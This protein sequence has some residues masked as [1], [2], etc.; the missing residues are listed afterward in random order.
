MGSLRT[1]I[2][3]DIPPAIQKSIQ[4]QVHN[5]RSIL[6]NSAIR[7]VPVNNIHLTLKFLGDVSQSDVDNLNQIVHK[8]AESHP[9]FD[10]NINSLGS[11]PSSK[12][13]RVLLIRVQAP[14][15]LE[16]LQ[17]G[18]E[19][20]CTRVGF[21][22]ES[23]PFNPHLTI[24]RV[25]RGISASDQSKIRKT[26]EE[27]KIDSLGTARVDSLH[28]YKSELKPSGSVYTKLYSAPLL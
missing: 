4:L 12:R 25:R 7:W 17:S 8:Q 13:A 23:R 9:A 15:E 3:L 5:L 19:S 14:A 18:L 20:D 11:F 24:G 28:L 22:P 2:A 21:R 27:V 1:F 10:I 16:A 6:G 26:L